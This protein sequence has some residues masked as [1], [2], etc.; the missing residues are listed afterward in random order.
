MRYGMKLL[1][2]IHLKW[3]DESSLL[4]EDQRKLL[5]LFLESLGI[6]SDVA[7]DLLH[8]LFAARAQDTALSGRQVRDAMVTLRKMRNVVDAERGLTMRNIQVWLKYFSDIRLVEKIGS[9]Y[10]FKSN[11]KPSRAFSEGTKPL[12]DESVKYVEKLLKKV[13]ES[14]NIS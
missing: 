13:E 4:E 7:R 10:H 9:R 6:T 2:D 8:V 14:F 11:K 12:V 5:E 1:S 3:Y